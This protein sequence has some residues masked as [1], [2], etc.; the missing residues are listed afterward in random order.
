VNNW[1]L[2]VD[3]KFTGRYADSHGRCGPDPAFRSRAPPHR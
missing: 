2:I 1:E 3:Q